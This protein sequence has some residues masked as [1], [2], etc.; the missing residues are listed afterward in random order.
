[1]LYGEF[2]FRLLVFAIIGGGASES[3]I[4]SACRTKPLPEGGGVSF[5][6]GTSGKPRNPPAVLL[7]SSAV[8][9]IQS[10][11]ITGL[12]AES[13]NGSPKINSH[14]FADDVQRTQPALGLVINPSSREA[15]I[16]RVHAFLSSRPSHRGAGHEDNRRRGQG[17]GLVP[18]RA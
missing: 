1:M 13:V 2:C 11:F 10:S 4:F 15:A 18:G 5:E 12:Q 8:A 7:C 6:N 16:V 17:R 3:T 9:H 14:P